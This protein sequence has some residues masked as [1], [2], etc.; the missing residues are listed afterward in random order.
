MGAW[1]LT[2]EVALNSNLTHSD[3]LT[4]GGDETVEEV[5]VGTRITDPHVAHRPRADTHEEDTIADAF[6][7]HGR[8]ELP[9]ELFSVLLKEAQP[10]MSA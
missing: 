9:T 1:C 10:M 4:Q 6:I 2:T 3:G 7:S 8:F 5:V